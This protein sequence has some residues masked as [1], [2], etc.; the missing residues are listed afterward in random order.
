MGIGTLN[1]YAETKKELEL[2]G[3]LDAVVSNN[4]KKQGILLFSHYLNFKGELA[5]V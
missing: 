4:I 1:T 5:Y 3:A 2:I